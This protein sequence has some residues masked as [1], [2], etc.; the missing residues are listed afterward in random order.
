MMLNNYFFIM[1]I[2]S[3][4]NY[5]VYSQC[6]NWINFGALQFKAFPATTKGNAFDQCDQCGGSLVTFTNRDVSTFVADFFRRNLFYGS[7]V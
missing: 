4:N 7:W 1:L 2:I 5:Y 6:Q 3:L